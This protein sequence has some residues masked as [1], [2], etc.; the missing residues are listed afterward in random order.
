MAQIGHGY[1]SE[2]H[3]MRFMGH[4]RELFE[5]VISDAIGEKGTFHWLD[6][7]FVP[8]MS[9]ISGDRELKGF[10]FL[11]ELVQ[12]EK[13]ESFINEYHSY[14]IGKIDSWQNW[15][16]IFILNDTFYL[17]EAKAHPSEISSGEK[18][19]GNKSKKEILRYFKEQ[20]SD[21][22]VNVTSEW[23]KDYYQLANRLAAAALLNKHGI[24]AKCLCIFFTHGFNKRIVEKIDG[25]EKIIKVYEDKKSTKE[26]FVEEIN[27][28]HQ[29]LGIDSIA[30]EA[31]LSKP[32]FINA[33]TGE[34]E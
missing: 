27:K 10:A 15:D 3:L 9:S 8:P 16:A 25:H 12:K 32:V 22:N 4:H 33:E 11:K 34:K 29:T 1:G 2:F 21:Y 13:Y 6:F 20:L 28:E 14:K 18:E 7:G 30:L 31:I 23:L 5:Q 17:V 24:K 19:H 26:G